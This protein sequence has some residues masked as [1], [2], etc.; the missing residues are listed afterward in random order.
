MESTKRVPPVLL[1][2][3][4]F[5]ASQAP[6]SDAQTAVVGSS[7]QSAKSAKGWNKSATRDSSQ[8]LA[9]TV[10]RQFVATAAETGPDERSTGDWPV[11]RTT[12]AT[13]NLVIVRNAGESHLSI[14]PDLGGGHGGLQQL[15]DPGGSVVWL[16]D[17]AH[18]DSPIPLTLNLK[19]LTPGLA[20]LRME[21][22]CGDVLSLGDA[23]DLL[24]AKYEENPLDSRVRDDD[25]DAN[26]GEVGRPPVGPTSEGALQ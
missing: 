11:K 25:G 15:I 4:A 19:R 8:D 18:T 7:G 5:G 24:T 20:S 16:C 14:T 26:V 17:S 6:A 3:L 10:L 22:N 13:G 2:L 21:V 9:P 23:H 12:S 1:V